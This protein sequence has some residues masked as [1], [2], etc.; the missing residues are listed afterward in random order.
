MQSHIFLFSYY[1][2][3]LQIDED[4]LEKEQPADE[5][6]VSDGVLAIVA[7]S[8]TTSTALSGLFCFVV[9]NPDCYK[10]LQSEVDSVFPIGEGDPFDATRLAD[11]PYL[12]AVM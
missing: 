7:G 12:N 8:D 10:R 1:S 4:K 6:V 5:E 2:H 11:M 3:S 9:A